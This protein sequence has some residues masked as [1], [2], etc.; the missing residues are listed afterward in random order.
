MSGIRMD[1]VRSTSLFSFQLPGIMYLPLAGRTMRTTARR[2]CLPL[3][4]FHVLEEN[5]MRS[6]L[7]LSVGSPTL[8]RWERVSLDGPS[9]TSQF[10]AKSLFPANTHSTS[11]SD[12]TWSETNAIAVGGKNF[13]PLFPCRSHSPDCCLTLVFLLLDSPE[14]G[15]GT[16]LGPAGPFNPSS[17]STGPSTSYPP[18]SPSSSQAPVPSTSTAASIS[19]TAGSSS[20]TTSPILGPGGYSVGG[21]GSNTGAIA[22]GTVGGIAAISIVAVALV[23]YWQRRRSLA[24]S[25][26]STGDGQAGAYDP[27]VSPRP[28]SGHE[29]V[30][31]SLPSPSTSQMRHYVR[32][33]APIRTSNCACV[34]ICILSFFGS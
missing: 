3:C 17:S 33:R 10:V 24:Q 6:T 13:S 23:F 29:T 19:H 14:L 11:Q 34:L 27:Q 7:T 2:N 5:L 9:S 26:P 30:T 8:S 22:G 31:S 16:I 25:A 21:H 15:P 20:N 32:S 4:E 12:N 18:N 1:Q 28:L